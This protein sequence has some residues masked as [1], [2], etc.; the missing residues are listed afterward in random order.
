MRD[1]DEI[2]LRIEYIVAEIKERLDEVEELVQELATTESD[3]DSTNSVATENCTT[4]RVNINSLVRA[5]LREHAVESRNT[6][7]IA[8]P[9]VRPSNRTIRE[10]GRRRAQEW[11]RE[12]KR[13]KT[14]ER[15]QRGGP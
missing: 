11:A 14:T 6:A 13:D 10:E 4:G 8:T 12:L 15:G 1:I 2:V 7:V 3:A 9:G 5:A